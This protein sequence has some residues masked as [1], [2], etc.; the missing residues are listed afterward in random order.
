M[1][2][3]LVRCR[4]S[5]RGGSF[6]YF[7]WTIIPFIIRIPCTILV[8]AVLRRQGLNRASKDND[9]L[10]CDLNNFCSCIYRIRYRIRYRTSD[11]VRPTYD[12]VCQNTGSCPSYVQY[13][14]RCGIRYR[15]FFTR[16]RTCNIRYH[17]KTYDIV[18]FLQVL[19]SRTCDIAYDIV[20]FFT[21]SHTMCNATLHQCR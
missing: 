8:I 4:P 18:R 12:I 10:W 1:S 20:R 6:R 15:T 5:F 7:K 16:H 13:R 14:I 17:R 3:V 19:I 9:M 21:M 11:I 2:D